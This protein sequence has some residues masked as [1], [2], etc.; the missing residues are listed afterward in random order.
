MLKKFNVFILALLVLVSLIS[1]VKAQDYKIGYVDL[2]K[3]YDSYYVNQQA[4]VKL[5]SLIKELENK[6]NEKRELILEKQKILLK[7]EGNARKVLQSDIDALNTDLSKFEQENQNYIAQNKDKNIRAMQAEVQ[8]VVSIVG[9][10]AGFDFII[11]DKVL[12]YSK[13]VHDITD[14]VIKKLK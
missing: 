12:V 14:V 8:N 6:Q 7:T 9:R 11:N 13:G 5:G 4:N 3:V 1:N 10:E 2:S